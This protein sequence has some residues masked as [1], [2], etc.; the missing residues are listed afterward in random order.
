MARTK[1]QPKSQTVDDPFN[2]LDSR[3]RSVNR[4]EVLC[5]GVVEQ[6]DSGEWIFVAECRVTLHLEDGRC[7]NKVF[8]LE[9]EADD[10]E[11]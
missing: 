3:G 7:L 2:E 5:H 6:K 1:K 8:D 4:E 11:P 10:V 9:Y